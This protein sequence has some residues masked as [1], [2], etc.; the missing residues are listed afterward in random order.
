MVAHKYTILFLL[1]VIVYKRHELARYLYCK[2][3]NYQDPV[4]LLLLLNA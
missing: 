4:F 2:E 3:H 1:H